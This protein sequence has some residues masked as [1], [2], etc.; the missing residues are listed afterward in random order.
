MGGGVTKL[1]TFCGHHKHMTLLSCA[2]FGKYVQKNYQDF[3]TVR[4]FL[5]KKCK[6]FPSHDNKEAE[7]QTKAQNVWPYCIHDFLGIAEFW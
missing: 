4:E 3:K 5:L 1:G 7:L 2:S 6:Y